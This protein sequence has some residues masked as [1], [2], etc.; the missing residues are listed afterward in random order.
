MVNQYLYT[1][2]VPDPDLIIR[3][4]GELRV[5]FLDL[6]G[7]IFK[8]YITPTYIETISIKMNIAAP[9]K[10]LPIVTGAMERYPRGTSGINA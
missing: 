6:A 9:W 10:H 7:G 2:I 3:T 4:S 5:T 8:W 1:A